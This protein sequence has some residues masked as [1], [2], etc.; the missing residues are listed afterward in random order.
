[1]RLVFAGEVLGVAVRKQTG[2]DGVGFLVVPAGQT[3]F[4]TQEFDA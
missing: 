2:L 4:S 3:R 1:M